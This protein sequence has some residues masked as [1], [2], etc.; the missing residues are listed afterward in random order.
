[1]KQRL[2][3][4]L[5]IG[6]LVT[7][8][9]GAAVASQVETGVSAPEE[10]FG[11]RPG[12]DRKLLDYQQLLEYL[13][14][15]A[16]ASPRV[17]VREIGRSAYGRPLVAVFVSSAANIA[18]L[19][20]LIEIN[21]R[22]A[23]DPEVSK[24]ELDHLVN[25]GRVFVL[26][27]HSMHSSEVGPAQSVPLVV[28][29]LAITS[30]SDL[31]RIL[32]EVVLTVVP[33]H[34]PDGLQMMVEHYRATLG[35]ELEGSSLP[36]V[37]HRYVGH[38]NNRDYVTLSQPETRAV[39]RLFSTDL[40]PHVLLDK[41]QMGRTGPRYFVPEYHDPIAVNI[42]ED[43]W[44]WSDV[45]GS[46]MAKDLGSAGLRGVASH[47]VFD[48]YWPGATTTSHWKGVI[49]LLTEAASCRLAT[50]VYVEPTELAVGGKGLAEYEKGVNMPDPWPGGW[51][52]LAD[53]IRYE[54][55]TMV[56]TLRTAAT[57]REELL[58]FRNRLCR[59][60]VERGRDQAP[61]Y[62]VLP[63]TQ[64]DPDALSDLVGLLAAHGI[65]SYELAEATVVRGRALEA[66]DVVVPLAQPYRAFIKEVM[67][68]QHYPV[69]HYTPD[70]QIIKPYD[71]TSWSLPLNHGLESFEISGSEPAFAARLQP[72]DAD[73]LEPPPPRLADG[74]WGAA[75]S[76]HHGRSYRAAFSALS[77]GLT[78]ER[79]RAELSVDGRPLP[80][81]SFIVSGSPRRVEQVVRAT[82]ARSVALEARPEA[83]LTRLGLPRIAVIESYFHDMDAGWTRFLFDDAG[84]PFQVVRPGEVGTTELSTGFDVIVLPDQHVDVL[85]KGRRKQ[86]GRYR[87]P[88]MAPEFR[89]PIS[90]QGLARLRAFIAGGGIVVSW[91]RSVD[92]VLEALD[93]SDDDGVE[94]YLPAR[95]RSAELK[96]KGLYVP[97]SLLAVELIGDHPL[98]WGMPRRTAVF[99]RASGV[100]ETSIPIGSTDRRV[101]AVH[102]KRDILVS[103][104]AE[105]EDLLANRP[106]MVWLRK[107]AGQLVLFGFNPQFRA[108][109][110]V[111]Y[112]L[113]W[114]A[115]LLPE[116][117][118]SSES[119]APG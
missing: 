112:P 20:Q 110:P 76:A 45:F 16:D 84:I 49:S 81:G 111:S 73:A 2:I 42:D 64:R 27:L 22:L 68:V 71:I 94:F 58:G 75:L 100:F 14:L 47:W 39:N 17:L 118:P 33:T 52:R 96:G 72:L 7:T 66:G 107:D 83:K 104:Y 6:V 24:D 60:E 86:G 114:N 69:R 43:L 85:T 40:F 54:M 105:E 61:A 21:R 46:S 117:D 56:S 8:G 11:F 113:L 4:W 9:S 18:R 89:R 5:V 95:N 59:Q 1:M 116:P 30:D 82:R 67:E 102:P 115:L 63:R 57:H 19:D 106:A 70:G 48:E 13:E 78:V 50:P 79:T 38:D 87:P 74:A 101:I 32:D 88:D 35:T 34:N 99:S 97:G 37:Y 44:Y 23:L 53:V 108:S 109:T 91:G 65:R 55:V 41:H 12:D 15:V 25:E 51:W 28:H 93:D 77:D 31:L 3:G 36:G 92:L 10:F 29:R 62:F 119:E 80:A 98:T 90:D 26:S 103:G